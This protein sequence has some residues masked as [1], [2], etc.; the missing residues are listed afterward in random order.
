MGGQRRIEWILRIAVACEFGGHG[1]F[2]ICGN[3]AW[4]PFITMFGFSSSAA[5]GVMP[6]VGAFDV[7]LA[8]LVLVYPMR[9]AILW[10]AFWS[11]FAAA[12]RP[13]SGLS[14]FEF[15][16]RG[17]NWGAPLA[18]FFVRGIPKK[19]RDWLR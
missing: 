19:W 13:L 9:A 10:M 3:A 7:C 11:L 4:V 5:V 8:L 1:Y 17:A 12:L 18:L 16:E 15:V 2:A 14:I 6:W